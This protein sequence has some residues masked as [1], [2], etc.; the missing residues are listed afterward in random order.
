[1]CDKWISN[2]I[3]NADSDINLFCIPYAG[4]GSYFFLKWQSYFDNNIKICPINIPG[5]ECR[6]SEPLVSNVRELSEQIYY[7]IKDEL[8]KPFAIF[9]HSM[10][11]LIAFELTKTILKYENKNPLVLFISASTLEFPHNS[12]Y[13]YELNDDEFAEHLVK[14]GGTD[15]ELVN[16]KEFRECFFPILRND[17]KMVET[18]QKDN[19][20]INCKISAFASKSDNEINHMQTLEFSK[21]TDNFEITFFNGSHFFIHE[22]EKDLCNK[23]NDVLNNTLVNEKYLN[24]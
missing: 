13:I 21:Y 24:I 12:N 22:H 6:I 17:Y 15:F 14:I 11:G 7:G 23:I 1:M 19:Q 8:S 3:L 9:G 18:Y 16:K 4:A 2:K 20:K 10:G 5:R